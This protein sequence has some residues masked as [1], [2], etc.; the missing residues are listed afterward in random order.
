MLKLGQILVDKKLIS[1]H[2][3]QDVLELQLLGRKKIGE[4]LILQGALNLEDLKTA[5]QEQIR[6]ESDDYQ[7]KSGIL[8]WHVKDHMYQASYGDELGL[9]LFIIQPQTFNLIN[10]S[11]QYEVRCELRLLEE[12]IMSEYCGT[13]TSLQMAQQLAE[14]KLKQLL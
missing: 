5:L 10:A 7:I 12:K 3:L 6:A 11:T 9:F 14:E 2:Q 4:I 13:T 8:N 1:S